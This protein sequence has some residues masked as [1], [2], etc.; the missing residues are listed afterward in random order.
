MD[1]NHQDYGKPKINS[2]FRRFQASHRAMKA[3]LGGQSQSNAI[4]KAFSEERAAR[5][6]PKFVRNAELALKKAL[7][8]DHS[9]HRKSY[10]QTPSPNKYKKPTIFDQARHSEDHGS[11]RGGYKNNRNKIINNN[12]Q[13]RIFNQINPREKDVAPLED[14]NVDPTMRKPGV[15]YIQNNKGD[16]IDPKQ[17]ELG[18]SGIG[19]FNKRST[20]HQRYMKSSQ[21]LHDYVKNAPVQGS[22][23]ISGNSL[24]YPF[25]Y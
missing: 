10:D 12:T 22:K 21:K 16:I 15:A 19:Y 5:K 8:I 25:G 9:I 13:F 17:N 1:K 3:H 6:H 2:P 7:H 20:R 11:Y 4:A 24:K 18:Y 23:Y 14:L